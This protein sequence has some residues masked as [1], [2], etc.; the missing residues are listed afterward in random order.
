LSFK[1]LFCGTQEKQRKEH[2]YFL[3]AWGHCIAMFK[4][5]IIIQKPNSF[6]TLTK[7]LQYS[8]QTLVYV[9][10]EM[11]KITWKRVTVWVLPSKFE[12]FKS[13]VLLLDAFCWEWRRDTAVTNNW[14]IGVCC[15]CSIA[16][17]S[18]AIICVGGEG[19]QWHF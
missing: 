19:V 14:S 2:N 11:H 1:C 13:S 18:V 9:K 3:M 4:L 12:K 10:I 7:C 6:Q 5:S 17:V 16:H 15:D 8:I